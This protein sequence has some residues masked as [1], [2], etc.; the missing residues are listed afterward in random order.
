MDPGSHRRYRLDRFAGSIAGNWHSCSL[1]EGPR[2]R[3]QRPTET[4][5]QRGR[6][7]EPRGAPSA[8]CGERRR[9]DR[10]RSRIR[11]EN[12]LCF[13]S[14]LAFKQNSR[15][16][17]SRISTFSNCHCITLDSIPNFR[18]RRKP[19]PLS[20]PPGNHAALVLRVSEPG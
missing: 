15:R 3:L 10:I 19:C 16:L 13:L 8:C 14:F 18:L 11:E 12:A 4:A 17:R 6:E 20:W 7:S 9:I 5:P 2:G 1:W